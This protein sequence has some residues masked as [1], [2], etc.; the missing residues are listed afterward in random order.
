L[1]SS[2]HDGNKTLDAE[3]ET[4]IIIN[5]FRQFEI[6]VGYNTIIAY[7]G[8]INSQ[9]VTF[10]CPV[11]SDGHDLS[12]CQN[13]KIRWQNAGSGIDG[14]SNLIYEETTIIGEEQK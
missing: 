8:D 14:N 11:F 10:A 2:L 4:P 12:K 6:P 1:I 9:I 5:K 3:K 7:E 13:K